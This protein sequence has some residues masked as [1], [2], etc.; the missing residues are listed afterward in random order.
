[1]ITTLWV[2]VVADERARE[3]REREGGIERERDRERRGRILPSIEVHFDL[4]GKKD[5]V[6]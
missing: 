6:F 4:E 5:F 2:D 3:G 1:M